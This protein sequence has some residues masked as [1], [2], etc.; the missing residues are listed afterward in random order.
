VY[1]DWQISQGLVNDLYV[2]G[3]APS[4]FDDMKSH[5]K[6]EK[7]FMEVIEALEGLQMLG[8]YGSQHR[9]HHH[10]EGYMINEKERK[11]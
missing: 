2:V 10:A 5:F 1:E 9:A 6:E 3:S 8:S 4:Q 11:F 7:M